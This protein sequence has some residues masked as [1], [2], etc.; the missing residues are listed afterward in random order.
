MDYR[1]SQKK[2]VVTVFAT[3]GIKTC[4]DSS[5]IVF[6]TLIMQPHNISNNREY[7]R[8]G[9]LFGSPRMFRS[10]NSSSCYS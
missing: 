5:A 7:K 1:V 9:V 2:C 6:V 8:R 3:N 4:R 10:T